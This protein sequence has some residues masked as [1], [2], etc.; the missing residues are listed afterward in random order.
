MTKQ[1]ANNKFNTMIT[2][3][4]NSLNYHDFI[5]GFLIAFVTAFI[6]TGGQ[7]MEEL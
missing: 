3:E 5:T 6:A 7:T 4:K 1:H 2:S